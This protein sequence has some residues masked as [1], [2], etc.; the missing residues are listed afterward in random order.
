[1]G[2]KHV[3]TE[4]VK[5]LDKKLYKSWLNDKIIKRGMMPSEIIKS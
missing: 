1:M 5:K 4:I 2:N 3:K